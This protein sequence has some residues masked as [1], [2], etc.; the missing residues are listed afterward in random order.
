MLA[1]CWCWSRQRPSPQPQ[2]L[3]MLFAGMTNNVVRTMGPPRIEVCGRG[4]G[5][6]A[7]FVVTNLTRQHFL[8]FKTASVERKTAVGWER[9]TPTDPSWFG[10]V[11]SL[12]MPGYGCFI[13]VGWPPGLP[14]N[15]SWRLQVSYGKDPSA[16]GRLINDKAGVEFFHSSKAE[17]IILSSEVSP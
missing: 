7:L 16:L 10:P 15:A 17:D 13:A 9:F 12:W 2:K 3:A 14:T 6:C 11:G 5:P 8:W 4:S 1:A